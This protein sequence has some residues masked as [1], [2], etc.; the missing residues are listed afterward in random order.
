MAVCT[1][2][3]VYLERIVQEDGFKKVYDVMAIKLER[4]KDEMEALCASAGLPHGQEPAVDALC[5]SNVSKHRSEDTG[6]SAQEGRTTLRACAD[7][8]GSATHAVQAEQDVSDTRTAVDKHTSAARVSARDPGKQTMSKPRN[9]SRALLTGAGQLAFGDFV[10]NSFKDKTYKGGTVLHGSVSPI[11][12]FNLAIDGLEEIEEGEHHGTGPLPGQKRAHIGSESDTDEDESEESVSSMDEDDEDEDGDVT[13]VRSVYSCGKAKPSRGKKKDDSNRKKKRSKGD[14]NGKKCTSSSRYK[15]PSRPKKPLLGLVHAQNAGNFRANT[16]KCMSLVSAI[17]R[18]TR[19]VVRT[20]DSKDFDN[21]TR[22]PALGNL[23]MHTNQIHADKIAE[24]LM[25]SGEAGQGD[26][27]GAGSVA[28]PSHRFTLAS[29]RIMDKFLKEGKLHP[30]TEPTRKGFLTLFAAC[31]IEEDLPWTT[32]EAPGLHRLFEYLNAKFVLPSDTTVHNQLG[33]LFADM[34]GEVVK[35]LTI[36]LAFEA[37]K[38][39]IAYSTDTWSTP[40]MVFSFAGTI[41]NFIDDNWAL[42][43]HLIDMHPL[44]DDETFIFPFYFLYY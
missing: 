15:R 7:N 43:E 27:A 10:S 44:G 31:I 13:A 25:A 39:K 21:E 19:T 8:S 1:T 2:Y 12:A 22:K 28:G 5:A 34:H 36:G 14:P 9:I 24:G 33:R 35:E 16:A 3:D 32:G 30:K 37:V 11:P 18:R 41:S 26:G 17:I 38:S 20:V 4:L 40:Q 29:A 42:I 23:A 6:H